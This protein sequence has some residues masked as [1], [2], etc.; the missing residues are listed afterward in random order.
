MI[1]IELEIYENKNFIFIDNLIIEKIKS[2]SGIKEKTGYLFTEKIK[3]SNEYHC[4]EITE[5]HSKDISTGDFSKISKK[6][7]RI[8]K[9][10]LKNNPFLQEIGFYHTHPY[11]FGANRSHYDFEHFSKF[12]KNYKLSLFIISISDKAKYYVYSFGQLV[13]EGQC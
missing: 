8:S 4:I 2:F 11:F 13:K 7:Q 9:K 6:H 10:I 3:N 1:K 12:S 5:P